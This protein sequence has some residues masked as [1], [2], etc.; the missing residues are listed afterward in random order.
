MGW[1][2]YPGNVAGYKME[3]RQFSARFSG[4]RPNTRSLPLPISSLP[5]K[6]DQYKLLVKMRASALCGREVFCPRSL[7]TT[8]TV[9]KTIGYFNKVREI[10]VFL[11]TTSVVYAVI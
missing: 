6:E 8:P 5:R 1:V 2:S 10:T 11:K 4:R 7:H 9:N 3:G